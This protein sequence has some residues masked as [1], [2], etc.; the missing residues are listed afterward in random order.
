MSF[1]S[2][3][4]LFFIVPRLKFQISVKFFFIICT[5]L[6]YKMEHTPISATKKK[7]LLKRSSD[8]LLPDHNEKFPEPHH[9]H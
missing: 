8:V 6:K 4:L 9:A 5:L 2:F 3:D 1:S 7:N